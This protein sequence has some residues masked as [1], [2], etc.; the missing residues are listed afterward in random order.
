MLRDLSFFQQQEGSTKDGHSELSYTSVMMMIIM[1]MM[2]MMMRM[3][4]MRMVMVLV[5]MMMMM[6]MM[7]G[8]KKG[9]RRLNTISRALSR[10]IYFILRI[11]A[12][13][14]AQVLTIVSRARDSRP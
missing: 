14:V 10:R 7:M 3:M 6:M 5:L 8:A 11:S 13:L 2:M 4:R 9:K 12:Y 1:M